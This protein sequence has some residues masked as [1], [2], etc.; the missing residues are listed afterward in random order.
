MRVAFLK[1]NN[2][3]FPGLLALRSAQRGARRSADNVSCLD[4]SSLYE[5]AVS[6][7]YF[8]PAKSFISL[9]VYSHKS[10]VLFLYFPITANFE[11]MICLQDNGDKEKGFSY[12]PEH[13]SS[14]LDLGPIEL[15]ERPVHAL[16]AK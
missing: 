12:V 10:G 6:G 15:Q 1:E 9:N 3:F 13:E 14:Y 16:G 5:I 7:D 11:V 4:V 8:E 2:E